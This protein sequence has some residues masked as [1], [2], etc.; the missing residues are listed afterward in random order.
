MVT[1]FPEICLPGGCGH[2]PAVVFLS[3]PSDHDGYLY[4]LHELIG[5]DF[6][7]CKLIDCGS[8]LSTARIRLLR[9]NFDIRLVV[10]PVTDELMRRPY[11]DVLRC[12]IDTAKLGIPVLVLVSDE[13]TGLWFNRMI[14]ALPKLIRVDL[15]SGRCCIG[16]GSG[17]RKPWNGRD[18]RTARPPRGRDITLDA[19]DDKVMGIAQRLI[20]ELP[21]LPDPKTD[22]RGED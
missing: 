13:N 18:H 10:L 20:E 16:S 17:G 5:E 1:K 21:D 14:P 12:L 4:Q 3:T 8:R 11:H 19:P 6:S 2:K 22:D 9:A 15:Y 7:R